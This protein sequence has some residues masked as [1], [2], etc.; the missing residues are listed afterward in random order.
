MDRFIFYFSFMKKILIIS[1]VFLSSISS[2]F[3]AD[4][5]PIAQTKALLDQYAARV[6]FLEAENAILREEMSKA[7]IKIPLDIYSGAIQTNN[8]LPPTSV[9]VPTTTPTAS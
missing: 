3:A 9:V 5:D 8:T 4:I 6:R 1:I 7:G 2:A